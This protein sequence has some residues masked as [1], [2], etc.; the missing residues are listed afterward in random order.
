[1]FLINFIIDWLNV[2]LN[3]FIIVLIYRFNSFIVWVYRIFHRFEPSW[4]EKKGR[5]FGAWVSHE[6]SKFLSRIFN[7]LVLTSFYFYLT[8][9]TRFPKTAVFLAFPQH[10]RLSFHLSRS[11]SDTGQCDLLT[12]SEIPQRAN[13]RPNSWFFQKSWLK[14]NTKNQIL[15]N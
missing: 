2:R 3:Y 5:Y 12:F 14:L 13:F 11:R 15:K 8:C 1:M 10:G 9:S 6:S 7:F 4:K